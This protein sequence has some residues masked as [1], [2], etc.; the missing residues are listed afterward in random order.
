MSQIRKVY[1]L[2]TKKKALKMLLEEE[3]TSKQVADELDID[4]ALIRQWK[5]RYQHDDK[6]HRD[7][8]NSESLKYKNLYLKKKITALED[9]ITVLKRALVIFTKDSK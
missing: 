8:G 5:R 4:S 3:K 6:F 9:E 7:N 2:E 1:T